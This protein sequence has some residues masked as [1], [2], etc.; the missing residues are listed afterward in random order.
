M[1]VLM[2]GFLL[3]PKNAFAE[4]DAE[5]PGFTCGTWTDVSV[6]RTFPTT[7]GCAITFNY[8]F[9]ECTDYISCGVP[10]III[11]HRFASINIPD[12]C[13]NLMSM[14]FPGYPDNYGTM[15][16]A[17]FNQLIDGLFLQLGK[18]AFDQTPNP[19][20]CAGTPP[21]CTPPSNPCEELFMVWYSLP[22]CRAYCIRPPFISQGNGTVQ[23]IIIPCPV[24]LSNACCEHKKF[25]CKCGGVT[26]VTEVNSYTQGNCNP[27]M[28]PTYL[29]QPLE[30]M[31]PPTYINCGSSCE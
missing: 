31:P 26:M 29:C 5:P 14:L 15:N 19:V 11:Q 30:G 24:Q 28:E 1:T 2:I 22:K 3:V 9:R 20:V 27:L 25:F 21:N 17:Y 8:Q 10:K 12:N 6:T 4:C 7:F 18:E 23:V 16:E 13:Y